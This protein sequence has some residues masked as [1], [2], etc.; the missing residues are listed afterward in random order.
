MPSPPY[1]IG[2]DIGTAGTKASIFDLQGNQLATT[3]EESKLYYPRVGCVEQRPEDFYTSTINT[4]RELIKKSGVNPK[5][6]ASIAF[7][8]QMAGILAID[9]NWNAVTPYD[10]WLDIRCKDYI[11]YLKRDH[12]DLL[13]NVTGVPPTVDHLPKMLWWKNEKPEIFE[14]I[15]KFT[16]PAVYVAGK[17]AGLS[18]NEAFYDYTYV[19]FTGLID[20][21]KMK[22][23]EE[24]SEI[25]GISLDKMPKI[26]KPW[27][28]VGELKADEA[29]KMGLVKGVPIVAGAGDGVACTLGAGLTEPG[30]CLDIAGTA[31]AFYV[32]TDKMVPDIKFKT[33]IYLKSVV[34]ELWNV[35]AYING[36]GLCLRWFRDEIA[37]HE[38]K[39]A[40]ERGEDPYKLLDTL[41]SEASPGSDGLFFVP[42][43]GG[44]A[45]PYNPKIRGVWFGFTW[46]HTLGYLFRA[47]LESICYE[48]YY[49]L[50]II[51]GLLAE[52]ELKEV[53][54][55]GG[56]S[57]SSVWNQIKADVLNVPYVLLNKEEYAV[58]ALAA[59]GGYAVRLLKDYV[60]AI[61]EWVKPVKKIMPDGKMHEKYRKYAKFYEQLLNDLDKTFELHERLSSEMY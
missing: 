36:G 37:K 39:V 41:A 15:C 38:K 11:D 47:I 12:A 46:R 21:K 53:R 49:Y 59:L 45:Y 58:L 3:Y 52:L 29:E 25:F 51:K 18:G 10:S 54:C 57:K 43:L 60:K 8:G 1:F 61:N 4:V 30:R 13:I 22:W 42:H 28:I 2:V 14:K 9:K 6:V 26:V 7:S 34:P 24:L 56:G 35:G 19:T 5:D 27:E 33:L 17:L 55:I 44:R 23:S 40:A 20:A 32:S 48:Y 50:S 16:V 31:S